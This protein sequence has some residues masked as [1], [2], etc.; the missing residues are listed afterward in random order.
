MIPPFNH[1]YVLPPYIGDNPALPVAQ[2]PYRTDIL[3]LC[4]H[5][6][7]TRSR[8]DIL[9]GFIQFRLEAYT[10]GI[11]NTIQWID[12]SFV[13]DKLKRENVEPNDIDVVTFVNMPQ[14]VQQAI[15]V[16][17]PDFVNCIAS[18]QK[19]HVDH[20]IIDISTPTAAVRNTQYWLQLFSHNRYGV[21]KGMLEIPLYQ[22]NTKDLMAMDFLNSLS[23]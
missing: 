3:D 2:S 13:E 8:V 17:F 16:A 7:T 6:G 22:D 4:K 23:L 19:Y 21:W 20:Y 10:H 15:L 1:N 18:K 9:K 11:Y 5:F 14:P 12:G